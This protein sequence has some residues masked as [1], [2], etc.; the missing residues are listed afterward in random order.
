[1][2][3]SLAYEADLYEAM[4][5]NALAIVDRVF[6]CSETDRAKFWRKYSCRKLEVL[7]NLVHIPARRAKESGRTPFSF[8]FVG[9][10]HYY[11]NQDAVL[12]FCREV[13]PELR[14]RANRD[15]RVRIVGV[16][17]P[18]SLRKQLVGIEEIDFV[19]AVLDVTPYYE[20]ADVVIVPIRAGGGTRIKILEAFAHRCPVVSTALGA[21]GIAAEPGRHLLEALTAEEFVCHCVT[22]MNDFTLREKLAEEAFRL[23]KTDYSGDVM[24]RVL[25][26]GSP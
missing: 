4:E 16:G 6:I 24:T 3:A 21:E 2:A 9:A 11:P 1:M 15:F 13:L 12:Y 17:A 10:F 18:R 5:R 25:C 20:A 26:R 19:G 8:L 14:R 23:V 22:L 7:P